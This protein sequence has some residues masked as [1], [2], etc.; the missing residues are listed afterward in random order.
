MRRLGTVDLLVKIVHF[1][2]KERNIF[3]IKGSWSELVCTRRSMVL[4]LLLQ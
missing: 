2:K 3:S 1:V 4:S